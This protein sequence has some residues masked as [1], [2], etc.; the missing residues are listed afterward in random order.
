MRVGVSV[1]VGVGVSVSVSAGVVRAVWLTHE[2]LTL[3]SPST[4]LV[5]MVCIVSGA[6]SV[7]VND[8]IPFSTVPTG[9]PSSQT[10]T[11]AKSASAGSVQV[12][13]MDDGSN[14]VFPR[15]VT[16][17]GGV[18]SGAVQAVWLTWVALATT[19]AF[20]VLVPIV[21]VVAGTRS[22]AVNL[23]TPRSTV[24]AGMPSR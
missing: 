22:V 11:F 5:Q 23:C 19:A 1:S 20:R 16:D 10:E 7:A 24:P 17:A 14:V 18:A 3:P 8:P 13:V 6:I 15:S 21:Y 9:S 12:Q 4:V 2:A